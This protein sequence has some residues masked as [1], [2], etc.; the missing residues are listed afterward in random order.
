MEPAAAEI[1]GRRDQ[2]TAGDQT[3]ELKEGQGWAP[4]TL[5]TEQTLQAM[6][7]IYV[8]TARPLQLKSAAT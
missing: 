6:V 3:C 2:S 5:P 1:S 8:R 7:C 4:T